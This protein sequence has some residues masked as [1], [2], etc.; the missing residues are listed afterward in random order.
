MSLSA[1]QKT[2]LKVAE[3]QNALLAPF[4]L[5]GMQALASLDGVKLWLTILSPQQRCEELHFLVPSTGIRTP[6]LGQR[7]REICECSGHGLAVSCPTS[8][9]NAPLFNLGVTRGSNEWPPYGHT[10]SR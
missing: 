7:A 10:F 5:V 3:E 9:V 1:T 8:I 4:R 6:Q 2:D